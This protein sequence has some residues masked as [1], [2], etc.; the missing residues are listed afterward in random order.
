[1]DVD[2]GSMT[3]R[4]ALLLLTQLVVPRPIAWVLSDSGPDLDPAERW[5]LAPFSYFNGV[6]SDPPLIAFSIGHGMDPRAAKDTFSNLTARP[7][8]VVHI[9]TKDDAALVVESSRIL[10]HGESEVSR[11]GLTT[12]PWGDWSVPRLSLE[13]IALACVLE[14]EVALGRGQQ[15]L[16][17]ARVC[18]AHIPAMFLSDT[19]SSSEDQTIR[20][21]VEDYSPMCQLGT[22]YYSWVDQAV[23]APRADR[24]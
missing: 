23:Y 10:P 20:V 18:R 4:A 15:V 13:R 8:F 11:L 9:P 16:M 19:G 22:G 14:Q 2:L 7:H 1:M 24:G 17:I 12:T 21:R 6:C 3:E 5:N